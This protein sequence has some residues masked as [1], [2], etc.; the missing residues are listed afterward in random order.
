MF[1]W[2]GLVRSLVVYW[3]PGR[4]R[5]LQRLYAPFVGEGDLVF[6]V[7]AHLGDRTAAFAALGA[8]VVALEP[9]PRIARWLRRL[10]GRREGVTIRTEAV[11][12]RPGVERLA[13][14]HRTPTVSTMS[15][16]WR[17]GVTEAH[18]GFGGVRWDESLEVP[19]VT[20]DALVDIYGVP[21]FCKID[22]E[23]Y[24][25]EV[26]A[27]LSRPVPALS[28]EFV[29]GQLDVATACVARLGELG[30]YAFNAVL[31]EGRDFV[32]DSWIDPESISSWLEQGASGASSGDVYARLSG[33]DDSP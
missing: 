21:S 28:L 4:R 17:T 20:L 8:R 13:V 5:G 18:P 7:G 26:L 1:E 11:G 31:G 6:D 24:E 15:E 10:V 12:A 14:S 23:G 25:A 27:G 33:S 19:V 32:F 30:T 3:R 16:A 22:V 29:A 2:I 9:Q